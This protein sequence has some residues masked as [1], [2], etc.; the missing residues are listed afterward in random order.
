M[1]YRLFERHVHKVG[2]AFGDGFQSKAG[3]A[4]GDAVRSMHHADREVADVSE[5]T[6]IILPSQYFGSIGG[7]GL[8]SEQRLMLAVLVDAINVLQ[9]WRHLGSARKR[10]AFAEAGQ[11]INSRGTSYPFSFESICDALGIDFEMLRRRLSP[12]TL[13]HGNSSRFGAGRL[14]LKESSRSQHMTANRV[15][16]RSRPRL[17]AVVS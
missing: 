7:G 13:G 14:R 9:G 5:L 17:K 8:C 6:D 10:R 16:H 1:L 2:A 4:G 12:L 15:R 3:L 11:W